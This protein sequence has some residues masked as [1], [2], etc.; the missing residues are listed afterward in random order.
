M[1]VTPGY[2]LFRARAKPDALEADPTG[3]VYFTDLGCYPTYTDPTRA[4]FAV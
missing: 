2:D 4:I 1:P 3:Q